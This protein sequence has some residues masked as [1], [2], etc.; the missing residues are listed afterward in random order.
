MNGSCT[1]AI[2]VLKEKNEDVTKAI[3]N[4]ICVIG[5]NDENDIKMIDDNVQ[6][7]EK[8]STTVTRSKDST[9]KLIFYRIIVCVVD[10]KCQPFRN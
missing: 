4:I 10:N 3:R 7:V 9:V 1:N 2:K 8:K 5:Q 6:H